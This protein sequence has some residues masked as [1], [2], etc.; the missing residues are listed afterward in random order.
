MLPRTM[1]R[2]IRLLLVCL[3]VVLVL[4]LGSLLVCK[5][6]SAPARAPLP[7]PNGYDDFVQAG[8]AVVGTPSDY[9]TMS[10]DNLRALVSTNAEALRVLRLGLTRRCATPLDSILTNAGTIS[11]QL[12]SIKHLAFLLA[13]EGRLLELDNRPGEAARSYT[14]VIQFANELSRGGALITRLVGIA[15]EN[16]GEHPLARLVPKLS[17]AEARSV[18]VELEKIDA[19]HVTWA[20]TVQNERYFVRSEL[21]GYRNPLIHLVSWWTT[22]RTVQ[23]VETRHN[24]IVAQERLLTTELALRCCQAEGRPLPAQLDGLV[25]NYLSRLP[26]DPF[27]AHPLVYHLRGTNWLLYSVGPDRVDD[28]GNPA[29]RSSTPITGDLRFDVP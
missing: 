26:A 28:G 15:C 4:A 22:W 23:K 27:S 2:M 8:Q 6:G 17:A 25:T 9:S 16:L 12:A 3:A 1:P 14:Q 13:A 20:E 21:R 10:V 7:N 19:T 29:S 18:I 11:S 5:S 24:M